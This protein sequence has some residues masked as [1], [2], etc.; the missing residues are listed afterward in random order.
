MK[1]AI[2]ISTILG[3]ILFAALE[4]FSEPQQAITN[5]KAYGVINIE[6]AP[7]SENKQQIKNTKSWFCINIIVNGKLKDIDS[8][9]NNK[10]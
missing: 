4:A 5:E 2:I 1:E 7:A 8:A 6:K 10:N 3:L 9:N